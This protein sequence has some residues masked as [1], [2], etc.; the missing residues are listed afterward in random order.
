MDLTRLA[1]RV[2]PAVD[3][4]SHSLLDRLAI[5]HGCDSASAFLDGIP[6]ELATPLSRL[7]QMTVPSLELRHV[8]PN[9]DAQPEPVNAHVFSIMVVKAV[10]NTDLLPARDKTFSRRKKICCSCIREDLTTRSGPDDLRT[11]RRNWWDLSTVSTCPFHMVY[12]TTACP[13]CGES[14]DK[15][16]ITPRHCRCGFDFSKAVVTHVS[17]ADIA[18]DNYLVSRVSSRFLN[19]NEFL[20]Q[21][22]LRIAAACMAHVGRLAPLESNTL[23]DATPNPPGCVKI[24]ST[25][26]RA[27]ASGQAG[28]L[29]F[30]DENTDVESEHR[31]LHVASRYG[32]L[33]R[34][35]YLSK[36]ECLDQIKAIVL[37]HAA[38]NFARSGRK[39]FLGNER[40]QTSYITFGSAVK[41]WGIKYKQAYCIARS[42]GINLNDDVTLKTRMTTD[43]FRTVSEWLTRH[44]DSAH[45]MKLLNLR[46]HVFDN[47]VKAGILNKAYLRF[48]GRSSY[49]LTNNVVALLRK[50]CQEAPKVAEAPS[51]YLGL[52]EVT[53]S[54]GSVVRLI[55]GLI[56]GSIRARGVLGTREGLP[57]IL[58]DVEDLAKI[59]CF[60]R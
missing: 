40:T 47:I 36:H 42:L 43:D 38:D 50:A 1:L 52:L 4:A 35:L 18:S 16:L 25:E 13:L 26:Y 2:R 56:E 37:Q 31:Y 32:S 11:F 55:E 44:A 54:H 34:W 53:R 60:K 51:G 29:R 17:Q 14:I 20:D 15:T 49:Y 46:L 3:E 19:T 10:A 21:M 58:L 12:L 7:G 28:L 9:K 48:P 45:A 22:P 57:A 59:E 41:K 23:T 5:R 33:Y 24:S 30:L 6:T 8:R 39:T 27:L